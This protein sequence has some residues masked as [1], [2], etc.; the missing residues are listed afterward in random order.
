M[1]CSAS[2][3][4]SES[5]SIQILNFYFRPAFCFTFLF[6][7][8]QIDD[9]VK[10]YCKDGDDIQKALWSR[11]VITTCNSAG[12]FYQTDTRYSTTDRGITDMTG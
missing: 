3:S 9:M 8:Q 6:L 12:L 2:E 11:I 4:F 10:P 5:F 1:F 7:W